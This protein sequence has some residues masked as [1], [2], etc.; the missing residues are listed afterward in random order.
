MHPGENL[1][2][3]RSRLG[4]TLREVEEE[5]E[6]IA[7][8]HGNPE[9]FV[10]NHWLTRLENTNSVPSVFKLF[11]LSAIYRIKFS[12]LVSLF[13]VD[14]DWLAKYQLDSPTQQTHLIDIEVQ[15][16]AK[17]VTFP[18]RFDR[19]FRAEETNLLSR[20]VE[21]WGEVPISL[22]QHLDIRHGRYG[23][24]GLQDYSM[25]P[26]L[27]PGSF[28][29]IDPNLRKVHGRFW[30][31]ELDRPI[32]FIELR[33]GYACSWCELQGNELLLV[34][35]SLSPWPTRRFPVESAEIVGQVTAVAMRIADQPTDRP[36][37]LFPQ[38]P[39]R[40]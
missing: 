9:F 3:L 37:D 18:V 10:S 35:H 8:V 36:P 17:K 15:D 2:E 38:L 29:Q 39:K 14:L 11:S 32:Y 5:S 4:I 23:Y 31:T 21:V 30:R 28:V 26:L 13:G 40:S 16:P 24:V 19:G 12:D 22:I 27:R 20:M 33:D 6:K 7:K 25:Y 34:P 1:R